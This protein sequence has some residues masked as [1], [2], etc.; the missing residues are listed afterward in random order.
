[1][2][3]KRPLKNSYAGVIKKIY[4]Q[5]FIAVIGA[6]LCVV[7][8]RNLVRGQLGNF[9]T[10]CICYIFDIYDWEYALY[11]YQNNVRAYYSAIVVGVGTLFFILIFTI[12]LRGFTKCFDA[13]LLGVDA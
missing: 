8:L 6:V 1:M 3:N 9:I 12:V 10:Q 2:K 7:F 11:L 5:L 4:K 13:I